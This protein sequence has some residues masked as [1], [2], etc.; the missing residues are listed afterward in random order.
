M[1]I[2]DPFYYNIV[3]FLCFYIYNL[4]KVVIWV[5]LDANSDRRGLC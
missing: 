3:A 2:S 1:K 4:L 5:K